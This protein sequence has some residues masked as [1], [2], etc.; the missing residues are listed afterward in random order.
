MMKWTDENDDFFPCC[1]W[2]AAL[3]LSLFI[4]KKNGI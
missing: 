1:G 3:T 2:E 4:F